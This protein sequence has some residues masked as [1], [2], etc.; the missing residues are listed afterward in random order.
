MAHLAERGVSLIQQNQRSWRD[1]WLSSRIALLLVFLMLSSTLSAASDT[2]FSSSLLPEA[3]QNTTGDLFFHPP[4]NQ[5]SVNSSLSSTIAVPSNQTFLG[6][7]LEI[8]PLWN[9]STSNGS[10]FGVSSAHQWNGTH[11]LTNGIGHGGKLTLATNSSLGSITN[12]ES[13]VVVAPGW[14]GTGNDHEVWSIQ[15]PSIV[16]FSSSSGMLV[17]SNGSNSLGFLATQALGDLGPQMDGCL[18]SPAIE[19]PVFVNNYTLTFEH[20]SALNDD[21]AAWVEIRHTNGTWG[22]LSPLG[23]YSSTAQLNHTPLTVWNGEDSDWVTSQ[24]Q[25]DTYVTD[26]QDKSLFSSLIN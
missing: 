26:M 10:Q 6:G 7:T 18:R 20:W 5:S 25:L 17:P 3:E 9:V 24:F 2:A 8:E 1:D 23:G 16:P 21:D 15:R 22:L 13:S 4:A 11:H 14:M 19:T 12:F